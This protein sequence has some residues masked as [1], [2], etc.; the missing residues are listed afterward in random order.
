[1]AEDKLILPDG[2]IEKSLGEI[3]DYEQPYR[4]TV[5]STNY[6]KTSGIPVLTAGKSFILG[7]TAER[8]NIYKN[9]PVIIFDDFTTDSKFVDFPF[10]VK[11]SAMKFLKIKEQNKVDLK[12]IFEHIQLLKIKETGGDHKRRWISEFSKF[13]VAL[14]D[15]EEQSKISKIL[16]KIDDAIV[17]TKILINKQERI[18]IGL[19]HDLLTKGMEHN[20]EMKLS[21]LRNISIN[22]NFKECKFENITVVSQGFQIPISRR[23]KEDGPN[24][25]VYI[26]VQYIN[27]PVKYLEFIENAPQNVI[28]S[29][30]DILFTR[31]GN[32]GQIVSDI[33]GVFHNNF[34]KVVFNDKEITRAYLIIYLRWKPIQNLI[35]DL[36]GTTTIPD[37][38][39]KDF[40][41]MPIFYPKSLKEQNEIAEII[42]KSIETISIYK[43]E[44]HK[45]NNIKTGLMQDMLTGKVRVKVLKIEDTDA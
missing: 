35:K 6:D 23:K 37:M 19:I 31:T 45:L 20:S 13:P 8:N 2:W 34:F 22:A 44:L 41:G 17:Q 10:K 4:Y 1:M 3:L 18:K 36:A 5:E 29:V 11:S 28:S 9:L 14:P 15:F 27:N 7:Y 25:E 38:K 40:Y 30:D 33:K 43:N 32:T 12:L 16:S 24:R 26:T 42:N 39:H 21:K